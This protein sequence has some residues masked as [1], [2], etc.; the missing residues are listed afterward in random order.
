[1]AAAASDQMFVG[2]EADREAVAKACSSPE[3]VSAF[4]AAGDDSSYPGWAAE[5][6]DNWESNRGSLIAA[7]VPASL[8]SRR[9]ALVLGTTEPSPEFLKLASAVGTPESYLE[10][11]ADSALALELSQYVGS[12]AK[13][14]EWDESEVN[15]DEGG[16]FAREQG[17]GERVRNIGGRQYKVSVS[18]AVQRTEQREEKVERSQTDQEILQA[19]SEHGE[20]RSAKAKEKRAKRLKRLQRVNATREQQA[21]VEAEKKRQQEKAQ[22]REGT[23]IGRMEASSKRRLVDAQRRMGA[24]SKKVQTPDDRPPLVDATYEDYGRDAAAVIGAGNLG[25]GSEPTIVYIEDSTKRVY[26]SAAGTEYPFTSQGQFDIIT[27]SDADTQTAADLHEFLGDVL[28]VMNVGMSSHDLTGPDEKENANTFSDAVFKESV[29]NLISDL[30]ERLGEYRGELRNT[31]MAVDQV[32]VKDKHGI[33]Q[34]VTVL[35]PLEVLKTNYKLGINA[36]VAGVA[37][38]SDSSNPFYARRTKSS[39]DFE[40]LF[41]AR[42]RV[43]QHGHPT[44]RFDDA[45]VLKSDE[46]RARSVSRAPVEEGWDESEV[47]RDQA[48]RFSSEQAAADRSAAQQ[49]R[50]ARQKRLRRIRAGQSAAAQRAAESKP[51]EQRA[52]AAVPQVVRRENDAVAQGPERTART[53]PAIQLSDAQKKA[54]AE[55]NKKAALNRVRRA[56]EQTVRSATEQFR[57]D[58]KS[59]ISRAEGLQ[60]IKDENAAKARSERAAAARSESRDTGSSGDFVEQQQPFLVS[61]K[62][63]LEYVHQ[64]GKSGMRIRK[65]ATEK[66]WKRTKE[67]G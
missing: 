23:A 53:A 7:G 36:G 61:G 32:E 64:A 12:V 59:G 42:I 50:K 58:A 57:H 62:H 52:A 25:L 1:M 43:N 22:R 67:S 60:K 26:T 47:N 28:Q 45:V 46:P 49:Q 48:G 17:T 63:G 10:E 39:E 34:E 11:A 19:R 13:A 9:A 56:H 6:I 16:R 31:H 35:V 18:E 24:R 66:E 14:D 15:R 38:S 44:M 41:S 33:T 55:R 8:A 65:P 29:T 20:A 51:V 5:S 2:S 37:I 54:V 40:P 30:N 3:V 4:H 21:K 27:D